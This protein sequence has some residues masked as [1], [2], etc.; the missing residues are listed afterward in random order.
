MNN[1]SGNVTNSSEEPVLFQSRIFQ[2]VER[3]QIGRSGAI[4]KRHIVKHPGAVAIV[5][6]LEDGRILL[7]KQFRAALNQD[8]YEIPAGTREPNEEPLVTAT[9]ELIEETGYRAK[10]VDYITTIY[11]SPGIL[12]EELVIYSATGLTLGESSPEDGERIVLEP[13]TWYEIESMLDNNEIADAKTI[14]GLLM[15]KRRLANNND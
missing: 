9:R 2:V 6:I 7:I 8:I 12:Q 14:V 4:L 10:S 3:E 15:T 13:K 5:P 11:T 1:Q